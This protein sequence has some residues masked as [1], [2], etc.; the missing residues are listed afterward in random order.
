MIRFKQKEFFWQGALMVGSTAIGMKQS[1]DAEKQNEEIAEQQRRDAA[2]TRKAL[3]RLANSGASQETKEQAASLFSDRRLFAVPGG[4]IKNTVGLAKDLWAHSG[5]GVKKAAKLGA[6]FAATGYVGNRIATSLKDHD[7]GRD[8]KNTSFLAKAAGTA[9]TIGGGIWAAKRGYLGKG[10]QN[11]MTTGAGS[12]AL[13]NTKKFLNENVSP[14]KKKG[15]GRYGINGMNAAF[16][17]IPTVMY[18]AGKKSQGDMVNNTQQEEDN[19]QRQYAM[20]MAS[21]G[22]ML[23]G[24]WG[25]TQGYAKHLYHNP[26]Q[27]ITGGISKLGNFVGMMGGKG[28]TSAVQA[29]AKKLEEMGIKSG[30]IYTQKLGRW[31]QDHKNMANLAAAGAT[32]GVGM[33][34]MSIGGKLIDK[35]MK[36]LDRDAY[37]MSEQGNEKV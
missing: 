30:N 31:A 22:G 3:D 11:F 23:K 17:A 2:K 28:G 13:T 25:K 26:G 4:F 18:A 33:G 1:S 5:G 21:I 8:D 10:A 37:K 34:A 6:G 14:I 27:A 36:A 16:M 19:Q 35:P 24:V 20:S 7:E 9:A 32:A 29:G 15:V 12:K